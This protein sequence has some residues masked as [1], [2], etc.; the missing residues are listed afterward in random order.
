M[1]EAAMVIE[2]EGG[3]PEAAEDIEVR[4]L[5]SKSKG[6]GGKRGLAVQAGTAQVGAE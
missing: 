4:R 2:R 1:R 3:T 6:G 5:G